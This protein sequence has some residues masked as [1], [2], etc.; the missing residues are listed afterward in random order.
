MIGENVTFLLDLYKSNGSY[1]GYI[2]GGP[3]GQGKNILINNI[4]IDYLRLRKDTKIFIFDSNKE[5]LRLVESLGGNY[6]SINSKTPFS[7]NHFSAIKTEDDFREYIDYLIKFFY[8]IGVSYENTDDNLNKDFRRY[9]ITALYTLWEANKRIE[10][11]DIYKWLLRQN[12]EWIESYIKNFEPFLPEGKYGKF[13]SGES[14]FTLGNSLL[15]AVDFGDLAFDPKL[16]TSIQAAVI[17]HV[18]RNFYYDSHQTIILINQFR[19]FVKDLPDAHILIDPLY[20]EARRHNIS[21]I[22][23]IETIGDLYEGDKISQTGRII[24]ENSEWKFFLP[25]IKT[26]NSAEEMSNKLYSYISDTEFNLIKSLR[27]NDVYIKSNSLNNSG[28]LIF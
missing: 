17:A 18:Y 7:V 24:I 1:N 15:A 6:I 25:Q 20:R 10:I 21:I 28:I 12:H 13:F 8:V 3:A 14:T 23:A 9:I 26:E 16:K 27:Y 19:E 2:L 5:H 4:I 11:S 22:T